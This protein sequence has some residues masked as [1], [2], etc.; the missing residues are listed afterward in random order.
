MYLLVDHNGTPTSNRKRMEKNL[1][2]TFFHM[3]QI[4]LGKTDNIKNLTFP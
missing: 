1:M 2:S 3:L 4:G